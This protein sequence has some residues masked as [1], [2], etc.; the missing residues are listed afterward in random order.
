MVHQSEVDE[1]PDAFFTNLA[2]EMICNDIDRPAS[3]IR[4]GLDRHSPG[5]HGT[6]TS[7]QNGV[8]LT[9]SKKK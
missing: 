3:R 1:S 2:H 9:P 6:G 7:L 8:A 5:S 4:R